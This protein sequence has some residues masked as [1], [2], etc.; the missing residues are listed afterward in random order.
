MD[1]LLSLHYFPCIQW[2]SHLVKG[3]AI[4]EQ[5]ENYSKGSYRNRC[6]IVGA[7]GLQRLSIPLQKGKNQ[8]M[9]IKEVRISYDSS[10]QKEH[11]QS[12]RSAYGKAPYF[13]FYNEEIKSIF[14]IEEEYLFQYNIKVLHIIM[15]ILELRPELLKYTE[16]Y[17]LLP[18]HSFDLRN[19]ISPKANQQI[20]D[21]LFN[22]ITYSQVFMERHGFLENVSILD[23]VFCLGPELEAHLNQ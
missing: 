9:P 11:W 3:N 14:S 23:A 12:I 22:P 19:G 17:K 10:W 21:P 4:I 2:F 8:Q 1:V 7:N 18:P 6:Q 13:E 16:S 5:H 20:I 15:E